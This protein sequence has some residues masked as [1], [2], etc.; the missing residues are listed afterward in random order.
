[1][2][3]RR[4]PASRCPMMAQMQMGKAR[5]PPVLTR[6]SLLRT[7]PRRLAPAR[8]Q[9]HSQALHCRSRRQARS[10]SKRCSTPLHFQRSPLTWVPLSPEDSSSSQQPVA[11]LPRP[12]NSSHSATKNFPV[13]EPAPPRHP[14]AR[15]QEAHSAQAEA[16]D[17]VSSVRKVCS[18][19]ARDSQTADL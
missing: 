17:P 12:P 7:T 16:S 11:A 5:L 2:S 18:Y 4:T 6:P 3:E 8:Q 19:Q 1:M 15:L 14:V 10:A 13:L 9:L